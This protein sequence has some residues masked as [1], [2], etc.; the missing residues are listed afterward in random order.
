MARFDLNQTIGTSEATLVVDAGM[1]VGR[2]R[3]Q[4]EVFNEAGR[5][6]RPDIVIVDIQR[7]IIDPR[8][9]VDPR[10]PINPIDPRGP[11]GLAPS[12]LSVNRLALSD[13]NSREELPARNSQ[14]TTHNRE[15]APRRAR[16]RKKP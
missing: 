15:G 5:R 6:S 13:R 9:P 4:L 8:D 10:G 12:E 11:I 14:P 3:F 1:P 2:H 16:R 7:L